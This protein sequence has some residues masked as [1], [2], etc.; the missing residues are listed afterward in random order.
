MASL[1]H[2]DSTFGSIITNG[3]GSLITTASITM[4]SKIIAGDLLV[5][6]VAFVA[7]TTGAVTVPAAPAG[8]TSPASNSSRRNLSTYGSHVNNIGIVVFTK[9]AVLADAGG[10]FTVDF[11]GL[12]VS[13]WT[14]EIDATYATDGVTPTIDGTFTFSYG[15]QVTQLSLGVP[16]PTQNGDLIYCSA[17]TAVGDLTFLSFGRYVWIGNNGFGVNAGQ[18]FSGFI[19]VVGYDQYDQNGLIGGFGGQPGQL[20]LEGAYCG[21]H[22]TTVPPTPIMFAGTTT[23]II[24]VAYAVKAA[25]AGVVFMGIWPQNW[26]AGRTSVTSSYMPGAAANIANTVIIAQ[27]VQGGNGGGSATV[28]QVV[29]PPAG[30]TAI[31]SQIKDATSN[32]SQDLF[33]H[34]VAGGDGVNWSFTVPIATQLGIAIVTIGLVNTTTPAEVVA[35]ATQPLVSNGA[36]GQGAL[37]APSITPLGT[38]ELLLWLF[39]GG[40][41]GNNG[42]TSLSSGPSKGYKAPWTP[43]STGESGPVCSAYG[44]VENCGTQYFYTNASFAKPGAAHTLAL[45]ASG[46]IVRPAANVRID[47]MAIIAIGLGGAPIPA[48]PSGGLYAINVLPGSIPRENDHVH[49]VVRQVSSIGATALYFEPET[50]KVLAGWNTGIYHLEENGIVV[51]DGT[52]TLP[53][54][55]RPISVYTGDK[56]TGKG[57]RIFLDINPG[58]NTFSVYASVDGVDYLLSA[59]VTGTSRTKFEFPFNITGS[60]IGAYITTTGGFGVV[61]V[62]RFAIEADISGLDDQGSQ[63]GPQAAALRPLYGGQPPVPAGGKS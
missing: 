47:Q 19:P 38:D 62:H 43:S 54:S 17:T 16:T 46:A 18:V 39:G 3:M 10:T 35:T 53:F 49:A 28:G 20:G 7:P 56:Y 33:F 12:N 57:Q 50:S 8:W 29:T 58:G 36:V 40:W 27:I 25:N 34:V 23:S 26:N 15:D 5:A 24:A 11:T 51:D 14:I 31:G 6:K 44:G 13:Y 21:W 41:A 30:W 37:V 32:I 48:P 61:E 59:A 22:A 60:V 2:R 45:K 4:S 63:G 55:L 42:I 1:V 9:T 52:G